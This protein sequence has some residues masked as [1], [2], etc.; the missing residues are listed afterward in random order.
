[1]GRKKGLQPRICKKYEMRAFKIYGNKICMN[2]F[3]VRN[4]LNLKNKS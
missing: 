1:M 3:S 2:L 4:T